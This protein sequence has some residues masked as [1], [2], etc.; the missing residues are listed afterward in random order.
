MENLFRKYLASDKAMRGSLLFSGSAA[1]AEMMAHMSYD[2]LVIDAEHTLNT[3]PNMLSMVRAVQAASAQCVPLVRVPTHDADY[4]KQVLDGVGVETLMFP[5]VESCEQARAL[6]AAC[7]YPPRGKRGHAGTVRPA[8]YGLWPRYQEALE[9]RLCLIA[10]IESEQAMRQIDCIG[11][12]PGIHSVFLGLGDLSVSMGVPEGLGNAEFRAF[13]E[14]G[15]A[16]C[17]KAG[18]HVGAFQFDHGQ[19]QWFLQQGGRYLSFGSDMR[20]ISNGGK[21]DLQRLA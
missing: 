4:L 7:H 1:V 19:A 11:Q 9:Q 17:R 6:V 20:Y 12:A 8:H 16:R 14:E 10:Q 13:V 2:F 3:L 21:A 5:F 18:L 15:M